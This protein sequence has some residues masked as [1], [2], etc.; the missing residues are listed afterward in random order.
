MRLLYNLAL[1]F[2]I[3]SIFM[4]CLAVVFQTCSNLQA[5]DACACTSCS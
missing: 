1:G 2:Y 3:S 5:V 4:T